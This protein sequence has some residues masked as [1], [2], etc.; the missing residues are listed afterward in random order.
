MKADVPV[1]YIGK[2]IGITLHDKQFCAGGIN[3]TDACPGDSGG[4]LMHEFLDDG[5]FKIIQYGIVSMGYTVCG[6][7][8]VPTVYTKV[9]EYVD[10]IL[11]HLQP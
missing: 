6:K 2:C 5:V 9:T 4:A 3:E 8:N 7:E 10:W 1:R 11:D